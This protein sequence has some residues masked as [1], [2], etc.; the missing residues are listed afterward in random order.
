MKIISLGSQGLKKVKTVVIT[1]KS[2]AKYHNV[3]HG[4]HQ[5]GF[6]AYTLGV[7]NRL[8]K[9]NDDED[10]VELIDDNYILLPIKRNGKQIID[11]RGN[12]MYYLDSDNIDEHTNDYIVLWN[13]PNNFYKDVK[14]EVSKNV[15]ELGVGFS[16]KVRGDDIYIS[17]SPLLEVTGNAVLRWTGVDK[18]GNKLKQ[19]IKFNG[20]IWTVG[21]IDIIENMDHT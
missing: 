12:G 13:I 8:H 15:L 1:S 19:V 10:K 7:S 20:D 17:P 4:S 6:W 18:D 9:V 5:S 16:G 2:N 3:R 11:G 14:Y 21:D